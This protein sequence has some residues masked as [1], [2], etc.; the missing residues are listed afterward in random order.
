[1]L[2]CSDEERQAMMLEFSDERQAMKL[3]LPALSDEAGRPPIPAKS[4]HR[5]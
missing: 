4:R 1:M 2:E 5:A 3:A